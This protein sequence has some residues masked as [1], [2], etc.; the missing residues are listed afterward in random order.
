MRTEEFILIP[1]R[2]F[3]SHQPV[4]KEVLDNPLYKQKAAQLSLLQRNQSNSMEKPEKAFEPVETANKLMIETAEEEKTE[5]MSEDSEIE[6]VVKKQRKS[7]YFTSIMI[8]L[9]VMNKNQIKRSKIILDLINQSETVTIELND[10]L[11]V[12]KETLTIKASTFLYNLQQP[13]KKIDIEKYSKILF[14]LNISPRLVANTHAKQILEA[15]SESEQEFFP[16]RKTTQ[17][18]RVLLY[19]RTTQWLKTNPK[20]YKEE[21][22]QTPDKEETSQKMW[23]FFS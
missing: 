16:S 22:D 13:T 18:T 12:N 23:S 19:W 15:S 10:V 2:M 5:P 1:K 21:T 17:S 7:D 20:K 8:E 6:P 3:A 4:K 11:H 14:A 9:E